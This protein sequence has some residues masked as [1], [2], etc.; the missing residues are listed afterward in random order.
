MKMAKKQQVISIFP[1]IDNIQEF[2]IPVE[3]EDLSD[4]GACGFLDTDD[5]VIVIDSGLSPIV[6]L[7]T[8]A[9]EFSHAISILFEEYGLSDF[10][11]EVLAFGVEQIIF[12]KLPV[13]VA[14]KSVQKK[15][16]KLYPF[17][18]PVQPQVDAEFLE[19][20]VCKVKDILN[21]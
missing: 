13:H 3:F 9:H 1:V 18:P 15:V 17:F 4:L 11:E 21:L 6:Q 10:E 12:Q 8:L 5:K 19:Q 20:H 2:G 14:L 16:E 7:Q